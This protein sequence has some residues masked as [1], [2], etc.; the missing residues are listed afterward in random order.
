MAALFPSK[1]CLHILNIR[2]R[3]R[4]TSY[5]SLS[6]TGINNLSFTIRYAARALVGPDGFL[7]YNPFLL[8]AL[9]GLVLELRP[10]RP[11]FYE[12]LIVFYSG[13]HVSER[14]TS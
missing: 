12:A 7:I 8:I 13:G 6:G 2:A 5:Q 10:G 4:L 11:F 9:W 14:T 3:S 1:S